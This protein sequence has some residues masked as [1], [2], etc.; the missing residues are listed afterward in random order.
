MY[1]E[2]YCKIEAGKCSVNGELRFEKEGVDVQTFAKSLYQELNW[3]Y[4][5]FFKMDKM[6]KL[7]LLASSFF[8]EEGEEVNLLFANASSSSDMD[9]VHQKSISDK[10]AFF[11]SPAVFVYTLPNIC[12][13]EISIKYKLY[14]ENS[15][16]VV[17]KF[18]T[19][20]FCSYAELLIKSGK[21]KRV[22]CAWIE[23]LEEDYKIVMYAVSA[24]GGFPH[25]EEFI[26]Q[27]I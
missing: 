4:P 7:S 11:P 8:L 27:I 10:N 23:V 17:E 2:K 9:L 22:L 1:I 6:S 24:K 15:F 25:S 18:P 26:N 13:G 12:L 21:A 19:S 16:F 14:S 20:F 3:Q 5:K